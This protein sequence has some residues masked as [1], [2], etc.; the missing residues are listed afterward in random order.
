VVLTDGINNRGPR[1]VEDVI[2]LARG[3]EVPLHMLGFGRPGELDHEV[4]QRMARETRGTYHHA[5][6][7]Q[8]LFEIFENLSIQLH[9]DGID[10][11]VLRKL[12]NATGGKYYPARDVARLPLIYRELAE[13]LQNTYTVKFPSQRPSHDGTSRG[14]D[15]SVVRRGV[16]VSEVASFDYSVHGVVVPEMDHRVYLGLLALLG[17]LLALP[18]AVRRLYRSYGGT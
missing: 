11:A 2:E 18:Q 10:E 8:R 4:M 17:G 5:S 6:D 13:E 9:D 1:R 15:I 14:I 12:A 7:E 16:R 3:A